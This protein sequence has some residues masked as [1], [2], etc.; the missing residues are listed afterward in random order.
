MFLV[1]RCVLYLYPR[2][3]RYEFG[4]EMETVLHEIQT[5]TE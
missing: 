3:H 2:V 1:W 4:K 5:E